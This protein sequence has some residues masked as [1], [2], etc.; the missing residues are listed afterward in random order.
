VSSILLLVESSLIQTDYDAIGE[1]AS[2][3]CNL[4]APSVCK[5]VNADPFTLVLVF[6]SVLQSTWVTMLLFVQF[7]QI[8][9]AM[10]TWENM[11]GA[12][13][14][15]DSKVSEAITSVLS[16]GTTSRA[17]AQIGN[18]GLGPDPVHSHGGHHHHKE[19][20]FGQWKKIL[21]VDTF[22]ETAL[23]SL[24]ATKAGGGRRAR[25][26][27]NRNPF[28]VGCIGNCKDFLCDSAPI[29]GK[30]ENGEAMLG[31]QVV[32][33]TM[34]YETPAIQRI[35]SHTGGYQS[36]AGEESV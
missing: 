23:G 31:G 17:G 7:V 27:G 20:C 13:H 28:S 4:L 5:I 33:Y 18:T 9:R 35:M 10:T 3:E 11:R 24:E 25:V 22:V 36:V 6:W 29:F 1:G 14:S 2:S 12:P 34:M 30:R 32:N 21:G 8:S 16:T 19:G 15:H 26:R